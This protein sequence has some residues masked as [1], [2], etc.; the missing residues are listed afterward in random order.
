MHESRLILLVFLVG[1]AACQQSDTRGQG[2][3]DELQVFDRDSYARHVEILA[4]DEF[5]GREPGTDGENKAIKYIADQFAAAG[6][7]PGMGDSYFQPVPLMRITST[8]GEDIRFSRD[9]VNRDLVIG[10]DIV[11]WTRRV[12]EHEE[13]VDSEIVF[14][15]Y[16]IVAPEYDWNDYDGLDVRGKTVLILVNDP[17]FATQDDALFKGNTMTYYGR[18][19]YKYEQA[20][21]QGAAAALIVHHTGG[22]GYG[23]NVIQGG[24]RPRYDLNREDGNMSRC[25]IEGWISQEAATQLFES[26]GNSLASV[27][28]AAKTQ[29]FRG[30]SLDAA[31]TASLDNKLESLQSNNVIAVLPGSDRA[32]EAVVYVAH[33]D[34]LGTKESDGDGISNG[35]VDNATGTAG[36][37]ELARAFAAADNAFKRSVVFVAATAEESGL[38]GSQYYASFPVFPM[39]DTAAAI[40]IDSMVVTGPTHEVSVVGY[41]SSELEDLARPIAASQGR[42]LRP[43]PSPE[44]GYFFRSDH[45]NFARQGVPA[46]YAESGLDDREHGFEWG[47]EQANDY[48]KKRYHQVSD[49]FDP[50]WDM[51]AALEDLQLYY[52]LGSQIA[53]SDQFPEWYPDSEFRAVREASRNNR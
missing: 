42:E 26:A 20:A 23:W 3:I 48:R 37:I 9:G 10:E 43:E 32:D 2:A 45:I 16:G 47:Q 27:M 1:I 44:K 51:G 50:R 25:N 12:I 35:A 4:S 19:T 5:G 30:Y 13:V 21:R 53:N 36:V 46:F 18:W 7:E 39:R 14:V 52:E 34:H 41:G 29:G 31:F 15:G 11:M 22:A 33:W 8:L 24:L 49:E 6:L 40:N 17:G 38:L 28:Q